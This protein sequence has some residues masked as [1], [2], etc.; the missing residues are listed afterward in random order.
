MSHRIRLD[1]S[2]NFGVTRGI[3]VRLR[4]WIAMAGMEVL[5]E[6]WVTGSGGIAET[7]GAHGH[8]VPRRRTRPRAVRGECLAWSMSGRTFDDK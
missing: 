6:V 1:T 7:V 2:I 4:G 3:D 8:D 5:L